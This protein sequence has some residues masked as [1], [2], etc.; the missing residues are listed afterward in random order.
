[1][2]GSAALDRRKLTAKVFDYITANHSESTAT[3]IRGLNRTLASTLKATPSEIEMAIRVLIEEKLLYRIPS[4]T[5][6]KL[7]PMGLDVLEKGGYLPWFLK[8]SDQ[9]AKRPRT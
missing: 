3:S 1:M 9:E 6:V 4:S 8:T 2:D 5:L 7:T